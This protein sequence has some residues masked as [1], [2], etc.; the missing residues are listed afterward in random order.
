MPIRF[1]ALSALAACT[2]AC[3]SS[4]TNGAGLGA[5]SGKLYF[6][7]PDG[8]DTVA[9][10]DFA[11]QTTSK[12]FAACRSPAITGPDLFCMGPLD[13]QIG[14]I[15][16][17]F[18]I[19]RTDITGVQRTSVLKSDTALVDFEGMVVSPDGSKLAFYSDEAKNYGDQQNYDPYNG[20][21]VITRDGQKVTSLE[22]YFHPAWTPSGELVLTGS[23]VVPGG[24]IRVGPQDG[25]FVTDASLGNPKRIDQGITNPVEPSV[26]PDGQ[27][28]AF[29]TNNHVWTINIDGTG[30]QQITTGSKAESYP[31]WSPDGQSIACVSQGVF[32]D[33]EYAAM[34]VVSATATTPNDL[35]F[36][37]PVWP[38][39]QD[40]NRVNPSSDVRWVK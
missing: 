14:L 37:A 22:G 23:Q 27:K 3:T 19:Y 39:T 18:E 24:E 35:L 40:G 10:Y 16:L 34:A 5:A 30:L 15:N 6:N 2:F 12:L 32:E 20:T 29:V 13:G 38:R 21:G 7:V 9:S 4:D 25:I 11:T 28:I 33:G 26:S 36:N 17:R 8:S 1:F 31:A